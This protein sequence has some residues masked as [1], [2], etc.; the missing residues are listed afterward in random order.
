M[1]TSTTSLTNRTNKH[2]I[3]E[4]LATPFVTAILG[5]RRV[6]KS[7]FLAHYIQ[8]HSHHTWVM[9]NM[10][11]LSEHRQ[12]AAGH[13]HTE[14]ETRA[15]QRIG[16]GNKLWVAI[17]EA[18][19][20]PEL[21]EQIKVLYDQFKDQEAIK[22]IITGSASLDLH[23]LSAESLAGRIE[24]LHLREFTI[25]ETAM[26]Q[27]GIDIQ[28]DSLLE[29][30]AN[31]PNKINDTIQQRALYRKHL[32][33]A[34]DFQLVYGGLP[35]V[36]QL[37]DDRSRYRYLDQYIQSYLEKDIRKITEITNLDLFQKLLEVLAEH[38]GSLRDDTRLI[39][40]LGCARN[41]LKKYRNCLIATQ[42]Y[43][44][45]FPIMHDALKRIIKS[46]KGYIRNNGIISLLTGLDT[47]PLLKT[48]SQIGHRFENWFL[49]E[50]QVWLDRDFKRHRIY[51]WHT[52]NHMEVDFIVERKPVLIPFEVTYRDKIDSKKLRNLAVF[53][54]KTQKAN[55]GVLIYNGEYVYKPDLNI[56]CIPAWAVG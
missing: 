53:M 45:I 20:C 32:E 26:L 18:Q 44:E 40:A 12:M 9:F 39:Q 42:V 5:P 46:P 14:I 37:N 3:V 4:S 11:I 55:V 27:S 35:E 28:T 34:L 30:I 8:H 25:Q 50:L 10:D 47:L 16:N 7:T 51:F 24:L 17:D 19:K 38:T 29:I 31:N 23:N 6:G 49:K 1:A 56:H 2:I 36:I 21:F 48:S 54:E 22:F 43:H 41:T 52:T 33:N 13:L 15:L